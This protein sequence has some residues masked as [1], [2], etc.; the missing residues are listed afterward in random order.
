VLPS[1]NIQNVLDA[2]CW[3]GKFSAD[4]SLIRL[5]R[6]RRGHVRVHHKKLCAGR[7]INTIAATAFVKTLPPIGQ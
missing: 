5:S 4:D 7:R 2:V 1:S 3:V 6:R